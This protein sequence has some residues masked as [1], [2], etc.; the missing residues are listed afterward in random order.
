MQIKPFQF[1]SRQNLI[2]LTGR[3][4]HNLEELAIGI[5]ETSLASIYYHTHHY[6]QQHE[7]L[8]PEPT[9]DYAYWVSNVLQEHLL[10]ERIASV[11]LRNYT[12]LQDIKSCFV[13]L[14]ADTMPRQV[15]HNSVP[16]GLEFHF[17]EART[18]ISPLPQTAR[19]LKELHDGIRLVPSN[20]I[21]YHMFESR[22]RLSEE[23]SDLALW[24]R[25]SLKE[26]TL[27]ERILRLDPYTRTLKNLRQGIL[28]LI[29]ER[30]MEPQ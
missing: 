14:M 17:L 13:A 29:E 6:L 21:Y 9:N 18:F 1:Y 20:S 24:L 25:D 23:T 4:A 3:R 27:A 8:S 7:Y 15:N 12:R 11:D 30:L 26:S 5:R 28:R 2:Y 22:L 10:G 19:D 16:A